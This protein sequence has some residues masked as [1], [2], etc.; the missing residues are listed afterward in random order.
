MRSNRAHGR[1]ALDDLRRGPDAWHGAKR[2]VAA[3][4]GAAPRTW[5]PAV[6]SSARGDS[7]SGFGKRVNAF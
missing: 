3:V 5:M 2:L 6:V 1:V 4:N 7:L